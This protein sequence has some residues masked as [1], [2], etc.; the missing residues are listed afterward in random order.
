MNTNQPK[1]ML[2]VE[3]YGRTTYA[4]ADDLA[5]LLGLKGTSQYPDAGIPEQVIHGVRVYV[6]PRVK[7]VLHRHGSKH[8]AF[9]ICV[10]GR[11]VPV[12]RLHQHKCAGTPQPALSVTPEED[13][14]FAALAAKLAAASTI[15]D[16][17]VRNPWDLYHA[18]KDGHTVVA[19]TGHGT[20][21]QLAQ[22]D[23]RFVMTGVTGKHSLTTGHLHTNA[24]RLHSHWE[25]FKEIAAARAKELARG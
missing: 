22:V 10:C 7:D 16:A 19:D 23:D 21:A 13:A 4:N 20:T 14:A 15:D 9:A 24:A 8:R 12:G 5:K 3:R 17:T 11:H 1:T 6:K 2:Y 25:G 18:V